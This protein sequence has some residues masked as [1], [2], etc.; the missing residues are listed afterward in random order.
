MTVTAY[1]FFSE[2]RIRPFMFLVPHVSEIGDEP[3]ITQFSETFSP[4]RTRKPSLPAQNE[5]S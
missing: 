4:A 5:G 3:R 1:G 2:A